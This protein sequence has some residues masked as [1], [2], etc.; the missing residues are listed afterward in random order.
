[1]MLS[2][3]FRRHEFACPCGCGFAAVDV[4]LLHVLEDL[5]SHF[6]MPVIIT[7]GCRCAAHNATLGGASPTS[8]HVQAMAADVVVR[9]VEPALVA[10]Y[11]EWRYPH[12]YGI[13]RYDAHTHIDVRP[14]KQRWDRRTHA[15]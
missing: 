13:G 10:H 15:N 11:L 5:R 3:H 2:I 7:S 12:T 6:A 9:G 14:D 1:M 8:R 4:E